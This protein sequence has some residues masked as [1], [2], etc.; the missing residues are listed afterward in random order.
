MKQNLPAAVGVI[1]GAAVL[2]AG[3]H[4]TAAFDGGILGGAGER[5]RGA[6]ADRDQSDPDRWETPDALSREDGSSMTFEEY[7]AML[8]RQDGSSM[9]VEAYIGMLRIEGRMDDVY[10]T[11]LALL[12]QRLDPR[13]PGSSPEVAPREWE[14]WGEDTTGQA[15]WDSSSYPAEPPIPP[16][17]GSALLSIYDGPPDGGGRY[18]QYSAPEGASTEDT[19]RHAH[20]QMTSRGLQIRQ[21]DDP[22]QYASEFGAYLVA[23]RPGGGSIAA[24][25][26]Q[27][28]APCPDLTS[29]TCTVLI[30]E[31]NLKR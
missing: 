7:L 17:P 23:D 11:Y 13:G 28:A 2:A 18:W 10:A 27:A 1:V 26:L 6:Q 29:F 9:T 15:G 24:H 31:M 8:A 25:S 30:I 16:P 22:C 21:G 3:L 14:G 19:C 5:E 4:L 20:R 12:Q